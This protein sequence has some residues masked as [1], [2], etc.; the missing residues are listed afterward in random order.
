MIPKRV[1]YVWMGGPTSRLANVCIE[2]WQ[3]MLPGF[4]IIEVG[5]KSKDWFD[6]A[7]H[8]QTGSW[9]NKKNLYFLKN[10][11]RI[12]LKI[13]LKQ[14]DFIERVDTHAHDKTN[15]ENAKNKEVL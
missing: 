1:F 12:P 13:L 10:K 2:N 8:W 3:M 5:E 4:E 7:V 9:M 6:Y 11:H 15:I 14:L